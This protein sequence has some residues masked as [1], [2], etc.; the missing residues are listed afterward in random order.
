MVYSADIEC[1]VVPSNVIPGVDKKER[2][3][4]FKMKLIGGDLLNEPDH[5]GESF[6]L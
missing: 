1:Y 6:I 2:S 5:A 4:Q 3:C